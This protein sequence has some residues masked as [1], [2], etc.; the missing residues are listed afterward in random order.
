MQPKTIKSKNNGCGTT[1]GNLVDI[2]LIKKALLRTFNN[3]INAHILK[4]KATR[5]KQT[6][7][8]VRQTLNETRLPGAV[9]Q[10]LF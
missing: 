9:P 8:L 5:D 10:Q 6:T 7:D 2:H 3:K 1:P 4:A